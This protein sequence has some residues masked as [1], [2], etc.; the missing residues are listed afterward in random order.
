MWILAT[1]WT[2]QLQKNPSG[3]SMEDGLDEGK[4]GESQKTFNNSDMK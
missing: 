4:T 1:Y 3:S 2:A